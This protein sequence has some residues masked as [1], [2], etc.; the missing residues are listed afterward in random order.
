MEEQ[1]TKN[2][3]IQLLS[4]IVFVDIIYSSKYN[5]YIAKT[6][7]SLIYMCSSH[8]VYVS[9]KQ[10]TTHKLSEDQADHLLAV[11]EFTAYRDEVK[12]KRNDINIE[13]QDFIDKV[14]RTLPKTIKDDSAYFR[15][16]LKNDGIQF[17]ID[18]IN[19]LESDNSVNLEKYKIFISHY[20]NKKRK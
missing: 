15:N 16:T 4:D 9:N 18:A 14:I 12:F 7:N 13:K 1:M 8:V 5:H 11:L 3:F 2:G 19:R 6:K 20:Y 17:F 10:K